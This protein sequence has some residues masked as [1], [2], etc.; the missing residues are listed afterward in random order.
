MVID[1]VVKRATIN[2]PRGIVFNPL[3]TMDRLECLDYADDKCEMSHR[4]ADMEQKLD[5]LANESSKVGLRIN[6]KKTKEMRINSD[7]G[8]SLMI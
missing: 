3:Q 7:N 6:L 5:D 1:A 8:R 4:L 2:K